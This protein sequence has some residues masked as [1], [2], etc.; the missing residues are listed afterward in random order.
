MQ[1]AWLIG[2]RPT[3]GD[4]DAL[5]CCPAIC[6]HI[7]RH[8]IIVHSGFSRVPQQCLGSLGDCTD[9]RAGTPLRQHSHHTKDAKSGMATNQSSSSADGMA[10][11]GIARSGRGESGRSWPPGEGSPQTR[12]AKAD[13]SAHRGVKAEVGLLTV[14]VASPQTPRLHHSTKV[15][16]CGAH[17]HAH[18]LRSTHARVDGVAQTVRTCV[19]DS[20]DRLVG[21]ARP[22]AHPAVRAAKSLPNN[23]DCDDDGRPRSSVNSA[24]SRYAKVR[25]A[26]AELPAFMMPQHQ[27]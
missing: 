7:Q 4:M 19:V 1:P 9:G 2:T 3:D 6:F 11:D 16:D 13:S 5:P 10:T 27:Q 20:C 26:F 18:G 21:H 22:L 25:A 17:L 14:S 15:D 24:V 23:A 12:H 8:C